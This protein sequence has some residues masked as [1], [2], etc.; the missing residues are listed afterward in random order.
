MLSLQKYFSLPKYIFTKSSPATSPHIASLIWKFILYL[1]KDFITKWFLNNLF[2]KIAFLVVSVGEEEGEEIFPVLCCVSVSVSVYRQPST[3]LPAVQDWSVS[4]QPVHPRL[5]RQGQGGRGG[6]DGP[7]LSAGLQQGAGLAGWQRGCQ[8]G[9]V[10][11]LL[12]G[13]QHEVPDPP[14]IISSPVF[15]F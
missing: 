12:G 13:Q 7:P 10:L 2:C 14:R 4:H 9:A 11:R 1:T 3:V 8:W 6:Q 15:C 5:S